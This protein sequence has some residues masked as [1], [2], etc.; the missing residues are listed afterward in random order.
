MEVST[1]L[2]GLFELIVQ[3]IPC[4]KACIEVIRM[5]FS[6]GRKQGNRGK[7]GH[8]VCNSPRSKC[9]QKDELQAPT[10]KDISGGPRM[11]LRTLITSLLDR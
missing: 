8:V 2:A 3:I 10:L 4:T 7:R 11:D 9:K 5:V 6:M 1:E